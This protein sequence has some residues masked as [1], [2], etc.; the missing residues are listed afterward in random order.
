MEKGKN[1]ERCRGKVPRGKIPK[2][3]EST[4]V[5]NL[6]YCV[7]RQPHYHAGGRI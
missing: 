2:N 5:K 6:A 3:A 7:V 1:N 4:M